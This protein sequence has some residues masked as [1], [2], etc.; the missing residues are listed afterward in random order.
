MAICG[1]LALVLGYLA[2]L[3]YRVMVVL[4]L[5]MAAGAAVMALTLLGMLGT[6]Q[7]ALAFLIFSV[8]VQTG[9]ALAL[10]CPLPLRSLTHRR[11]MRPDAA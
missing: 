1:V 9:Y 4:P 7:A 8:A 11:P 6:G 10:A 3:R 5:E 2:G